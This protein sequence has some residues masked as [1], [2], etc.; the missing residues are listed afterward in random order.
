VVLEEAVVSRVTV[1]LIVAE[2]LW[3]L[4]EAEPVVVSVF[5]VRVLPVFVEIVLVSVVPDLVEDVVTVEV[6]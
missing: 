1:V 5:A 6:C 3:V 4:V 2:L